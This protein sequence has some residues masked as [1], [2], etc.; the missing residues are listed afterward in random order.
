MK[1]YQSIEKIIKI[2]ENSPG[3][4]LKPRII[5]K[6]MESKAESLMAIVNRMYE[7]QVESVIKI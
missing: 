3:H 6:H 7:K 1:K 2:F 5:L 4:L